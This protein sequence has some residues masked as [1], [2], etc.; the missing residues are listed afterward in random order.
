M[1]AGKD[2]YTLQVSTACLGL[3]DCHCTSVFLQGDHFEMHK[4]NFYPWSF[5]SLLAL[6]GVTIE[7]GLHWLAQPTIATRL[8]R[9]VAPWSRSSA[10]A[11]GTR[12]SAGFP[13]VRCGHPPI[14]VQKT[15]KKI[16]KNFKKHFRSIFS[17]NQ[18]ISSNFGFFNFFL[19]P[20]PPKKSL[21]DIRK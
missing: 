18:A 6:V 11:R 12:V 8:Q 4:S 17:P 7:K 5:P 15:N 2:S 10:P 16:V 21:I 19:L 3:G 14:L 9:G 13:V 20:R 1:P